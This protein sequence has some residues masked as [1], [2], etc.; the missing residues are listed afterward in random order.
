MKALKALVLFVQ[1][2]DASVQKTGSILFVAH[3][4]CQEHVYAKCEL[5]PPPHL[6]LRMST[7]SLHT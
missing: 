6:A 2:L 3:Y 4:I 7:I 5:W 1:R